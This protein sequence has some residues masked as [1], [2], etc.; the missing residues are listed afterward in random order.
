MT[1][2]HP[3]FHDLILDTEAL[4]EETEARQL[5]SQALSEALSPSQRQTL[6]VEIQARPSI[7]STLGLTPT[8]LPSLVENNPL[9]AIEIL[10]PLMKKRE[11]SKQFLEVLANMEVSVHSME[12]VN[13]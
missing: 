2:R 11:R 3:A 7:I 5:F 1:P 13:R 4:P 6:I 9:V 10:L 12:V 8:N